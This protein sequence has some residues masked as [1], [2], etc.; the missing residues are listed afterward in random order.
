MIPFL[1][2]KAQYQSIKSDIDAAVS[3]VLEST[4]FVL[5]FALGDG[6]FAEYLHRARHF[7]DLVA[8]A[9]ALDAPVEITGRNCL[10]RRH[11]LLQR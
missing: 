6:A 2:L 1:D 3:R 9:R 11:D 10:H 5:G 7:A 8:G 4:Q